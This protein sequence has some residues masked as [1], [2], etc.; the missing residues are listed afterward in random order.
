MTPP[1][2]TAVPPPP[3]AT[4]RLQLQ[5][6]F[7]FADAEAHIPYVASL[8]VSH[9][10]LSPVL[11]PVPGSTHGYDVVDHTEVNP[12]LGGEP[13][14]RALS[15][16][17]RAHGLGIILDTVPNH[18]AVPVPETLSRPLWEVLRD[19]PA[20]PYSRWFDV[21]WD[22]QDGRLFLPVLGGP[23]QDVLG[24]LTVGQEAE[25]GGR[26]L[27][28][29]DHL[30]PLREG[31]E[32]L[33]LPEL[34]DVQHYRLGWWREARTEV[35]YRRFFTI[36]DLI[37]VRVE[38]PDVFDATHATLLRLLRDGTADGL[39][40]DHPDGLADPAGYLRR[41]DAATGGR[42]T[43]VEKIL[44]G[45]E[46]L[47][48][49]WPCAGTTGYDALDRIDGLFTDPDGAKELE[50]VYRAFTDAPDDRGGDW[51]ATALRAAREFVTD[52]LAAEV[53][54]LGRAAARVC[55]ADPR[56]RDLTPD[57]VLAAL[58]E[59]LAH[60]PCYRPY[61]VPGREAPDKSVLML[62]AAAE[63]AV[64]EGGEP[65]ALRAVALVHDLALGVLGR[66]ADK[67]DFLVRFPQVSSALRAKAVEDTAFYRY[68]PLLS[69][70]EVG[71]E[72]GRPATSPERFHSFCA[73]VQRDLPATGTV[74]ST[75]DTKRSADVRARLAVLSEVPIRWRDLLK[76]VTDRT[77]RQGGP[78]A[79]DRQVAYLAWQTALGIGVPDPDRVVPALLKAV[80]EAALHTGWTEQD[81]DYE[82]AVSAFTR[83]GPC[84]PSR[85]VLARFG[86]SVAACTRANVLGMALLHLTM[87][88][89]PDLYQGT[90][91]EY[92]A[93]V[94]PDNRTPARLGPRPLAELDA[95][96]APRNLSEEKL[97]LTAAALR[98]RR[99]HPA[100]FGEGGSYEPLHALGPADEHCVAFV[101]TG[102]AVTAVTRLAHRL[103]ADGGWRGTVLPLPPGEW[104]DLLSGDRHTGD[105]P[106]GE[107]FDRYPV[108]L[109]TPVDP[110]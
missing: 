58:R 88:G 43:V 97:L 35:N 73:R 49:D 67:D 103:E 29:H 40:I 12:E 50:L 87:P 45:E 55:A 23:V 68:C 46:R 74:L 86:R 104:R 22:A 26:V 56:L 42:W 91:G 20:S 36:S 7:T 109:L 108:A 54:R 95:G 99:E 65:D 16:T 25:T 110:V 94:D 5:P 17:A 53:D 4:Y 11:R 77:T 30:F 24:E 62:D 85:D 60:M 51:P 14:L 63:G 107:L 1:K 70:T 39:R 92:L 69:A 33:P 76:E 28:Y 89:V 90:E 78:Q 9:L 34:L 57:T 8:G 21:D 81:G 66:S 64:Q 38:D 102:Q 2:A 98:L 13:G 71:R 79:P 31:T 47:P 84:G 10:H 100:W 3:T 32:Q 75:H 27:R 101:R 61:A 19:G 96:R 93:L 83:S 37:A 41:L 52:D 15:R 59:V 44:T 106:T 18:M 105:V 48:A 72:P 80:R 82:E 6:G